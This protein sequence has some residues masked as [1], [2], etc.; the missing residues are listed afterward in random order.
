[1]SLLLQCEKLIVNDG[2]WRWRW[3]CNWG[4][5]WEVR[6]NIWDRTVIVSRDRCCRI[7]I[8]LQPLLRVLG[9]GGGVLYQTPLSLCLR[10]IIGTWSIP[11]PIPLLLLPL[12]LLLFAVVPVTVTTSSITAAITGAITVT[13]AV[14]V[15]VAIASVAPTV[16][17]MAMAAVTSSVTAIT[18][19]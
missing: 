5:G 8:E 18:T 3:R 1:M 7:H 6:D 13:V 15:T 16:V 14:A 11:I 2:W 19:P 9:G 10:L 4:W 12:L 17:I